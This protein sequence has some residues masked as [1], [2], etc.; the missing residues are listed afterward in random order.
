VGAFRLRYRLERDSSNAHFSL[1]EWDAEP[2]AVDRGESMEAALKPGSAFRKVI[3]SLDPQQTAVTF[4]VYTDSF[5]IYRKLRDY[6]HE[7]DIVVAGR[8]LPDGAP[9]RSTKHGSASRGQ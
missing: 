2:V 3:D 7:R 8:P 5:P 4:W 6:L 1:T 9:I